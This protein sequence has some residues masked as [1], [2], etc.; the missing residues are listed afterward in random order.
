MHKLL[1]VAKREY[2]AA[3]R[4]K[5]FLVSLFVMPILM[6]GGIGVQY[7]LKDRVDVREKRVAVVDRTPGQTMLASLEKA[8]EARKTSE[9]FDPVSKRQIKPVFSVEGVAPSAD[10]RAAIE[11]QRFDLSERVRSGELFGFFEIGSSVAELPEPSAKPPGATPPA[12]QPDPLVIRYQSNSPTYDQIHRWVKPIVET[13]VREQRFRTTGLPADKVRGVL[14]PVPLLI[15]GLAHRDVKTGEIREGKDENFAVSLMVP[16]ALMILMFLL[17]LVGSTPAMQ[18]V[19]EEKMYKIAEMVLG[20]V[21][22]FELML[23]KVLGLMGVSL[24]L[25]AI[26]LCGAY[27]AANHYG[28]ADLISPGILAWFLVYLVVAIIMYGSMFIAVGAACSDLQETQ[29]M[30]WPVMLV[31]MLPLFIWVNVAREPASP[32]SLVVSL[33]PTATPML[34]LLRLA[35]PPGVPWWQPTLGLFLMVLMTIACVYAAGRIFRV[36]ILMQ[37]K[38]ASLRDLARWVVKG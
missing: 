22:P 35:V 7:L 36:G 17:I 24:T 20:S 5:A 30:L 25:A 3:V 4:T 33:I 16:A 9:V 10:D 12:T 29:T 27:W 13:A 6:G 18:G 11:Q 32:F 31:A 1:V 26:Y 23:G 2:N 34:M 38:G 15:K 21:R 14:E 37:G 19:V 8:A 28:V